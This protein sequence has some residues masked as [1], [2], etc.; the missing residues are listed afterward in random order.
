[1]YAGSP[2]LGG[3]PARDREGVFEFVRGRAKLTASVVESGES[4]RGTKSL[5][6]EAGEGEE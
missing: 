6:G 3:G 2:F 1:M 5:S 4:N